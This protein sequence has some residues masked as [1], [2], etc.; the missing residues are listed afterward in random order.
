M[1]VSQV[2]KV[3]H[4]LHSVYTSIEKA[5]NPF[6]LPHSLSNR[7]EATVFM[8]DCSNLAVGSEFSRENP[9]VAAFETLLPAEDDMWLYWRHFS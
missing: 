1:I 6:T 8:P 9:F 5:G 3:K 2:T 7:N 4:G